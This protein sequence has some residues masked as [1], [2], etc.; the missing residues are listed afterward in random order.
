MSVGTLALVLAGAMCHALWN[1]LAKRAAGGPLFVWLFGCVSVV[2]AA[3]V[4]LWTWWTHPQTFDAWMWMA[5]LASGLVHVVYSLVLQ[6]GYRVSDFAVVYPVARGTGPL[7][8]VLGA[9]VLLSEVPSVLG[10]L[11]VALVLGGVFMTA[12]AMDLLSGGDAS[13]RRLGVLWGVLTGLCIACYTVIDGWAVKTLGM[14]PVLFYAVGLL[15]RTLLLAPWALHRR[16]TLREQWRQHRTAIIL[17]GLLSPLAY[18]L[19]LFAVQTAPLS[20]VAP[21]RE[22]S[23]LIGTLLGARLLNESLRRSQVLG[24]AMMLLGVAGLAL[25]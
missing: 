7:M 12:G 23:M 19:V 18:S 20:Y 3:P 11:G 2:A 14:V 16:A 1:I 22:I 9:V 5:A 17:V 15:F 13:R 6:Q 10:W 4:A 25:A 24:A 8:S 21:V